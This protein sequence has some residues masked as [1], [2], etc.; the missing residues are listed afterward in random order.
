MYFLQEAKIY[1]SAPQIIILKFLSLELKLEL[2]D[3]ETCANLKHV[4]FF[5]A[6]AIL[7]LLSLYHEYIYINYI[8]KLYT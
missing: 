3:K 2:F 5:T 7:L 8:Y 1:D 4:S 6:A